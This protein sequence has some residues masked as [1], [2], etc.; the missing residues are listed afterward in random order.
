[1]EPL[2][3]FEV[4][5]TTRKRVVLR[6]A[7]AAVCYIIFLTLLWNT[8]SSYYAARHWNTN[9]QI[10][11][12]GWSNI[13]TA[14][15]Q[16]SAI[17]ED[18]R[19]FAIDEICRYFKLNKTEKDQLDTAYRYS[20][21]PDPI[22]GSD[23]S[24]SSFRGGTAGSFYVQE[25]KIALFVIFPDSAMKER[26]PDVQKLICSL[27][28][29][30]H[31]VHIIRGI[32]SEDVYIEEG[33]TQ[34]EVAQILRNLYDIP[35]STSLLEIVLTANPTREYFVYAERMLLEGYFIE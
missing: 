31:L 4:E 21:T 6:Y 7:I 32:N 22:Y 10:E 12:N 25:D 24:S 11:T 13:V 2:K 35:A 19:R 14:T 20:G 5:K 18:I 26:M 15:E 28:E 17:P 8:A 1:M 9:P 33:I 34:L 29:Y 16:N 27:H 30:I 3:F 23:E